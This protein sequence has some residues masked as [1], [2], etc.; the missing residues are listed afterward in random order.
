MT[1]RKRSGR[2]LV[3]LCILGWTWAS[4]SAEVLA[5]ERPHVAVITTGG[6]IAQKAD[7]ETGEVKP[8]V[9]GD[10][11]LESVPGL[12]QV[13]KLSVHE[14]ANIDSRDM[15]PE[16]WLRM[17][18]LAKRLLADDAVQGLVVVH[19]TDTIAESAYVL[20]LVLERAKP[21]VLT[22]AMRH[23]SEADAEGPR[24]LL[25]AVRIAAD[26]HSTG[27]GVVV[28]LNGAINGARPVVKSNTNNVSAFTSGDYGLLGQVDDERVQ[29]FATPDAGPALKLPKALPP[30]ELF[31]VYPGNDA[32]LIDAAVAKG[33]KGLV[34]AGYGVGNVNGPTYA[35]IQR[36][37][38]KGVRVVLSTRVQN[39]RVYPVYGGE[40]GGESLRKLGVLFG[41]DLLPWKARILLMLALANDLE[42]KAIQELYDTP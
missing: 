21:V 9:S 3:V 6:T 37:T 22:G 8:T 18:A 19:G 28:A 34:I 41:G 7:P 39:G 2:C 27:R 33:T 36:A 16:L 24:N 12:Q 32:T 10:D 38:A 42:P 23:A 20:S 1:W 40:G 26:P 15:T 13:A 31:F 30:V 5:E 25:N 35:A 29:W 17:A 4:A 11:L 14:L